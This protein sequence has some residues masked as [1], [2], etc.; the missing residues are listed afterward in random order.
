MAVTIQTS[1][2]TITDQSGSGTGVT[3]KV[4]V[5]PIEEFE[6]DNTT[7]VV[8]VA[9]IP[10]DHPFVDGKLLPTTFD[11]VPNHGTGVDKFDSATDSGPIYLADFILDTGESWR[12]LWILRVAQDTTT[13]EITDIELKVSAVSGDCPEDT[14]LDQHLLDSDPHPQYVLDDDT[15][16]VPIADKIPKANASGKIDDGWLDFIAADM[17]VDDTNFTEISGTDVQAVVDSIDDDLATKFDKAG[18]TIQPAAGIAQVILKSLDDAAQYIVDAFTGFS[19]SLI[20]RRNGVDQATIDHDGTQVRL[21]NDLAP[22]NEFLGVTDAGLATGAVYD[23]GTAIR[24][25][26]HQGNPDPDTANALTFKDQDGDINFTDISLTVLGG[27]FQTVALTIPVGEGI[28]FFDVAL[29]RTGGSASSVL[30]ASNFTNVA[31]GVATLSFEPMVEEFSLL[32][33]NQNTHLRWLAGINVTT[34]AQLNVGVSLI[35]TTSNWII[36]STAVTFLIVN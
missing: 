28:V 15:S 24:Q 21:L 1:S 19:P 11:L 27:R 2:S 13:I 25:L 12:E 14:E 29:R 5:T 6:Y 7:V 26:F 33:N 10:E 9:P 17:T 34:A 23:D 16:V 18:G 32:N 31:S 20:L 36:T 4:T 3:G 8:K 22:N 30:R 35:S